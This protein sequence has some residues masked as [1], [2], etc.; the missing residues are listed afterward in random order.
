MSY[1]GKR[2][3]GRRYSCNHFLSVTSTVML[4]FSFKIGKEGEKHQ[5]VRETTVGCLSHAPTGHPACK[6][7]MCPDWES[8]WWP[9]SSQAS[10]QSTEH[11][12]G[13]FFFFKSSPEDMFYWFLG[14]R[15]GGERQT[16]IDVGEK[17]QFVAFLYLPYVLQLRIEPATQVG[18]PSWEGLSPQ[19]LGIWGDTP[20]NWAT[21]PGLLCLLL[22]EIFKNRH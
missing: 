20:T 16:D 3:L 12:P 11:Q 15:G 7:G 14:G 13:H 4:T 6:P 9:L 21:W 19:P 10:T 1:C 8:N 22:Y 17:H 18:T 5:C 2:I